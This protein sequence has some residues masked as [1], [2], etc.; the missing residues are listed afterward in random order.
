MMNRH[1]QSYRSRLSTQPLVLC[2]IKRLTCNRIIAIPGLGADPEY[3]WKKEKVH[4]L[5]DAN[6][7]PK[8]IPH[9]KISVFQYQSQ[10]FGK[11]SVDERIDNVANKLLHGLDRSR[12]VGPQIPFRLLLC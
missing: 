4:W 7:L 5:R 1:R 12:V 6:M 10:W 2:S 3:T 11:G 8:K 9:A